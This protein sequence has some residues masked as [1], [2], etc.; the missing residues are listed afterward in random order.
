MEK[1]KY[2]KAKQASC[3]EWLKNVRDLTDLI[4]SETLLKMAQYPDRLAEI[5]SVFEKPAP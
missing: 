3:V 5:L 1:F 2:L 4:C